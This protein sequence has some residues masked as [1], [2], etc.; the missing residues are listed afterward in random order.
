M[1]VRKHLEAR[2]RQKVVPSE[3]L[4]RYWWRRLD[5]ELFHGLREPRRVTVR[6]MR[7]AY[8][9]LRPAKNTVLDEDGHQALPLPYDLEF[10][11]APVTR[12]ALITILVHEMVHAWEWESGNP[13]A[14]GKLF[15]SWAP[16]I[17]GTLGLPL[18]R[19]YSQQEL[20]DLEPT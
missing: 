5:A 14:H 20:L 19:H 7:N 15:M 8:A 4:L 13:P 18:T 12:T 1:T 11:A 3:V 9:W 2:G 16:A 10:D 17:L 6:P